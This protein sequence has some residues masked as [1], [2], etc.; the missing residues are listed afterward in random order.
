MKLNKL[1][2]VSVLIALWGQ[3]TFAEQMAQLGPWNVHYVVLG[4][5]FLTPEVASGYGIAR[6]RDRALMNISVLDSAGSPVQVDISGT[7]IN[8]LSQRE[9]LSFREVREGPAIYYLAEFKYTDRDVLRFV[10]TLI[11]PDGTPQQLTF[12]QKMYWDDQ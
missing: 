12:Q 4:T 11:P 3:D 6:G 8:L 2:W 10:V 9:P 1:R 7:M 5:T